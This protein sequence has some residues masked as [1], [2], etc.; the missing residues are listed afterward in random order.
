MKKRRTCSQPV[1]QGE[2]RALSLKKSISSVL[3]LNSNLYSL[4]LIYVIRDTSYI[5]I[6]PLSEYEH[7]TIGRCG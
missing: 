6:V 2:N 5:P 3:S 1:L 4:C 7:R